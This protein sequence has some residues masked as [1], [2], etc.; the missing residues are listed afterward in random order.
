MKKQKEF[1]VGRR[2]RWSST[3]GVWVVKSIYPDIDKITMINSKANATPFTTDLDTELERLN[4][5]YYK[6]LKEKDT[7]VKEIHNSKVPGDAKFNIPY[8]VLT[9]F[10]PMKDPA[11]APVK[12]LRYDEIRGWVCD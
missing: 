7:G 4:N 10:G 2:Y 3:K 8:R 1:I 6:L 12:G 9:G 11:G 5:G